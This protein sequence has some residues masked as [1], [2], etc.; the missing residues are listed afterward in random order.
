[1]CDAQVINYLLEIVNKRRKKPIVREDIVLWIN[2]PSKDRLKKSAP[3]GVP[4]ETKEPVQDKP[5]K[6]P[7]QKKQRV[8]KTMLLAYALD[9]LGVSEE[10]IKEEMLCNL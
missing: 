8:T 9:K 2:D 7:V 3:K 10:D 1:M 4:K 5:Q 6:D